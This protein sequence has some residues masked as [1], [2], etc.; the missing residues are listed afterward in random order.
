[1]IVT[2][3]DGTSWA[4]IEASVAGVDVTLHVGTAQHTDTVD[5]RL[6]LVLDRVH[7]LLNPPRE[8]LR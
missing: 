5:A 1:M 4:Y 2:S 3:R 8:D 6:H 7:D